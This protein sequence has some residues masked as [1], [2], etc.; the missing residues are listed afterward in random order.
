MPWVVVWL[1]G[2]W[3][4]IVAINASAFRGLRLVFRLVWAIAVSFAVVYY[5]L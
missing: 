1:V 5:W 4:A 2:L 3:G